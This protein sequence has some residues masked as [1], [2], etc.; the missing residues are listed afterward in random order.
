MQVRLEE[1]C[2]TEQVR[3]FGEEIAVRAK[4]FTLE[5]ISGHA[6]LNGLVRWINSFRTKPTVFINHGDEVC[7]DKLAAR[8]TELGYTAH[9][10]YSGDAYSLPDGALVE[11]GT[12]ERVKRKTQDSFEQRLDDALS[13]LRDKLLSR[14]LD[15]GK[16][17]S[18]I[19]KIKEFT[20]KL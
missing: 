20:K 18:V 8:L 6:D 4:I 17:Q 19:D 13:K 16:Q 2:L 1:L 14:T 3:I 11:Q 7:A 15:G 12:R 5:G 9:A 10:P